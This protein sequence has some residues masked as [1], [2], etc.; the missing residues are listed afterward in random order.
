ME[1]GISDRPS[2]R[3]RNLPVNK[4][5]K[6]PGDKSNSKSQGEEHPGRKGSSIPYM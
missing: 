1:L 5:R 6:E 2:D 3:S 4:P